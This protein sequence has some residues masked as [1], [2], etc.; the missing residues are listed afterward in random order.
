MS[1]Y[2]QIALD[3]YQNALKALMHVPVRFL[4]GAVAE[5][6]ERYGRDVSEVTDDLAALADNGHETYEEAMTNAGRGHLL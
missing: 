3:A 5:V 6:A 2:S 1:H 4:G